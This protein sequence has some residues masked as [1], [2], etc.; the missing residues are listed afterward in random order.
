MIN[1]TDLKFIDGEDHHRS[2][3]DIAF[4]VRWY[5]M[6]LVVMFLMTQF[7]MNKFTSIAI[8]TYFEFIH[9]PIVVKKFGILC[10][11][12]FQQ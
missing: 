3:L 5:F 11:F 10:I 12:P 4:S 1:Y 6:S 9:M 7:L 2:T 8:P